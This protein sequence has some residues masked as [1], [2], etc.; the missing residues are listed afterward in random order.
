MAALAAMAMA[1]AMAEARAMAAVKAMRTSD[2]N[3][4]DVTTQLRHDAGNANNNADWESVGRQTTRLPGG[5][6]GSYYP[7]R[8]MGGAVHGFVWLPPRLGNDGR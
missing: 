4:D 3:D 8:P 6:R 1:A 2:N 5:G 7:H